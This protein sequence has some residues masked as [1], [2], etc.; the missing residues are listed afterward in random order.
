MSESLG[1]FLVN[2]LIIKSFP[3]YFKNRIRGESNTNIKEILNS[4][5]GIIKIKKNYNKWKNLKE[6][7]YKK[8]D[9]IKKTFSESKT[10]SPTNIVFFEGVF[11]CS[12]DLVKYFDLSVFLDSKRDLCYDRLV[13]RDSSQ[14]WITE[15]QDTEDWYFEHYPIKKL[16]DI[17]LI[18]TYKKIFNLKP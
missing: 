4:L 14:E 6:I 13:K 8:Y 5:K 7:N 17:L 2:K 3:I 12:P 1:V 18:K 10:F 16:V 9:W 15:W 11:M